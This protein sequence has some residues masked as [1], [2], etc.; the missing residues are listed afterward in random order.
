MDIIIKLI[1]GE[2]LRHSGVSDNI[3]ELINFN[4]N[5]II[6]KIIDA[7]YISINPDKILYIKKVG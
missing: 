7:P 5:V 3:F 4:A 1:T 2:E 6:F